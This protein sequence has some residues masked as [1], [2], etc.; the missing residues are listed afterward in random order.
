MSDMS[1]HEGDPASNGSD[2]S[3]V[4][5]GKVNLRAKVVEGAK[6]FVTSRWTIGIAA[7]TIAVGGTY[8]TVRVHA[9]GPRVVRGTA[10]NVITEESE[11]IALKNKTCADAVGCP[12]DHD[13]I[14]QPANKFAVVEECKDLSDEVRVCDKNQY[15]VTDEAAQNVSENIGKPIE[16]SE[17]DFTIVKSTEL[18][19]R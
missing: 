13:Y 4:D 11:L 12:T 1:N 9:D 2:E 7:S 6:K 5:T 3:K 8:G 17:K 10:L 18:H 14:I 16:L 15:P 19:R